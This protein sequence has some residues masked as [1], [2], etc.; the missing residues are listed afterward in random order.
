MEP[1]P[2]AKRAGTVVTGLDSGLMIYDRQAKRAHSLDA[3]SSCVWQ[4]SDGQHTVGEIAG[5]AKRD[6]ATVS[7]TL[8]QLAA[9]G[10]LEEAPAFARRPLLRRAGFAAAV[11]VRI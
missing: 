4:A 9:R 5:L 11:A 7:A 3:V 8:E 1:K 10:L 2:Q 6:I